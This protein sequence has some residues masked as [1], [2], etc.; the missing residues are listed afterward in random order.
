MAYSYKKETVVT[1]SV[2]NLFAIVIVVEIK[3]KHNAI[4]SAKIVMASLDCHKPRLPF[5]SLFKF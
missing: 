3:V 1:I 4:S 2:Q 5:N